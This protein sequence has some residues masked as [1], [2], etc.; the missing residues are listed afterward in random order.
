MAIVESMDKYAN[1]KPEAKQMFL[2]KLATIKSPD[3]LQAYGGKQLPAQGH[4]K[5]SFGWMTKCEI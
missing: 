1:D 5:V 2:M 3:G 4:S